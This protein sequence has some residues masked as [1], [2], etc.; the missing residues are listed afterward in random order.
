MSQPVPVHA[1]A[2]A[3][4]CLRRQGRVG[5]QPRAEGAHGRWVNGERIAVHHVPVPVAAAFA[6]ATDTFAVAAAAADAVAA[7]AAT[8]AAAAVALLFA[9]RV[10]IANHGADVRE[11]V[12]LT[13]RD[14]GKARNRRSAIQ[15]DNQ[16]DS[17][18]STLRATA[19]RNSTEVEAGLA[20]T[21]LR[22][23]SL[24]DLHHALPSVVGP[25]KVVAE[26]QRRGTCQRALRTLRKRHAR[27]CK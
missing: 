15:P 18:P 24:S 26:G 27:K 23:A 12:D 20:T 7:V 6:V 10:A 14:R 3:R 2:E 19:S 5:G 25:G 13:V 21:S 22:I 8:T 16:L 4:L 11:A 17:E 9:A 1:D